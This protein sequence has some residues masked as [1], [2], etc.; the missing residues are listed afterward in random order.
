MVAHKSIRPGLPWRLAAPSMV[1][2]HDLLENVHRLCSFVDVVEIV[3]FHT[4]EQH[5][6]PT[7]QEI[8]ELKTLARKRGV[9]YTV[10]LPSS[11][12]IAAHDP[13]RRREAVAMA[14]DI[15]GRLN[16]VDP[17]HYILHIPYTPPTLAPVPGL[18]FKEEQG[19]D[20]RAWTRR[21]LDSVLRISD[22]RRRPRRWLVENIN[23]APRFLTP[24]WVGG[25]CRMCL[26]I[27]HLLLGQE[28]VCQAIRTCAPALREIHLHGVHGWEE[29][30]SLRVRSHE[31]VRQWID[32]LKRAGFKGIF[33]LEV[34]SPED[35]TGSIE[36]LAEVCPPD[37]RR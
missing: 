9:A 17:E 15:S 35:L 16:A 2:G 30:I 24:F 33:N 5:N 14:N 7:C 11:L 36:M 18:Y 27:G 4:P 8:G 29:H 12:E 37:D 10:H 6:L 21:A 3:L 13:S 32:E 28:D 19:E 23:Y 31:E 34:F 26:D 22:C 20:W 25:P 1:F